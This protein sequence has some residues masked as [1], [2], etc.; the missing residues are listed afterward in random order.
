VAGR[1]GV[2]AKGG[3]L[4]TEARSVGSGLGAELSEIEIGTSAVS[5]IHGLEK[6]TLSVVAVE[7]DAVKDN[8]EHF[9]DNLNDDADQGPILKAANECVVDLLAKDVGSM[10]VDARP[11]PHVLVVGVVF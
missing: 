1:H 5:H 6:T 8:A 9:D 2:L 7:D 11:S 4:G 10:V 3:G